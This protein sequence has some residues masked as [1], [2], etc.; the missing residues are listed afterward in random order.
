VDDEEC[1]PERGMLFLDGFQ[2]EE[3][4]YGSSVGWK[5]RQ[6][7]LERQEEFVPGLY[8]QLAK[9]YRARGDA[10]AARKILIAKQKRQIRSVERS[11]VRLG[12]VRMSGVWRGAFVAGVVFAAVVRDARGVWACALAGSLVSCGLGSFCLGHIQVCGRQ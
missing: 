12:P 9:V 5:D 10:H 4:A 2:Y 11:P 6:E 7:W 1:R 3:I 8:E